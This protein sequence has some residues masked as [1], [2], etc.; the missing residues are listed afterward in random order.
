[1]PWLRSTSCSCTPSACVFY[2]QM[3]R[4]KTCALRRHFN[5]E[6]LW[7][8]ALDLVSAAAVVQIALWTDPRSKNRMGSTTNFIERV[9]FSSLFTQWIEKGKSEK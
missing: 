5:V 1:M 9:V 3:R 6:A 7:T 2:G 8:L 4:E